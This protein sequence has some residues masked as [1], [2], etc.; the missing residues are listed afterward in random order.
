MKERRRHP[1]V[2]ATYPAVLRDKRGRLL[3]RG[4]TVNISEGGVFVVMRMRTKRY[5]R[6]NLLL[7]LTVPK[8]ST[9]IR[10]RSTNRTVH[11]QCRVVR[12]ESLGQF[13]GLGIEFIK[14]LA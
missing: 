7:E 5:P 8:T 12:S 10:R 3:A 4:R 1:R 2:A 13:T 11:Y 14:K 9:E 6:T